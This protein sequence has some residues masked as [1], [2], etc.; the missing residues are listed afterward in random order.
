P[1][2][3]NNIPPTLA[4]LFPQSQPVQELG[5]PTTVPKPGELVVG[6][7]Q[8][9]LIVGN[10]LKAVEP[11][12]AHLKGGAWP[13]LNSNPVFAADRSA[14]FHDMPLYYG[15]FNAKTVFDLLAHVPPAQPNPEAPSPFP[16]IPWDQV[17]DASG[18]T[19]LQSVS[20]SYSE[21]RAGTHFNLFLSVPASDR[22][23][24]LQMIAAATKD[25][26]PPGFVPAD[27]IKFFRW[28]IDGRR[29][30]DGLQ[31]MLGNISPTAL[32]SLN[33]VLDIANSTAQ[34]KNPNFD[35]RQNL[36]ANLGDDFISYQ[37]APKGG[38]SAD[39]NNAPSL[40]LFAANNPDEAALAINSL[41]S[42]LPTGQTPPD[43]RVFLGRKI[44]TIPLASRAAPDGSSSVSRSLYFAASG[45]YVALTTDVSL[46]EN[47]LRGDEGHTKPLRGIAGL[48]D[49]AQ[50]VGGAGNG[51]FG[52]E[53]QRELVRLLF[54]DLKNTA[55]SG[56]SGSSILPFLPSGFNPRQWMDFSLL[57]DY[58]KVSKYFY[59]SVYGGDTTVNGLSFKFFSPKPPQMN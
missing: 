5:R 44:Y 41:A 32:T 26:N 10:S 38:A 14:R 27:A 22:Q 29:D 54:A 11:V 13:S 42:M 37:M 48:A 55:N 56:S 40:F 3:T 39:L 7:F 53:N 8:S 33:S 49:A 18:L 15:W 16:Q 31:K 36:L 25:A 51:L 34:Q 45:G 46:L 19:G 43:P 2:S 28:R 24:I 30:W 47:Y 57:P 21:S 17:L 58:D 9:L 4:A 1:L 50:H 12:A 20:F 23:G 52:Y 6:Q 35:I 59:F